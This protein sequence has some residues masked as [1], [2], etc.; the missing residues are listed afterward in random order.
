[1][2]HQCLAYKGVTGQQRWFFRR[3]QSD[4]TPYSVKGPI[5]GNHADT[6]THAAEQGLGLVVFP[7]WLI[8]ESLR[9]GTLQAVLTDYEVATTLEPQQIAALWPGSRR[10]SLKVRTVIDYFVE[11]FGPVPYWD[12]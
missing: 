5:T 11:C 2:N 12:R 9:A 3:G 6:L 4:W 10:L 8:G 1:M 7:S